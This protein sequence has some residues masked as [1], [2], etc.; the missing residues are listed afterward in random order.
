MLFLAGLKTT[1]EVMVS[2]CK[3]GVGM[4]LTQ[5]GSGGEGLQ[6]FERP[7]DGREGG[8]ECVL[9]QVSVLLVS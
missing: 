1:M 6:P 4:R 5:H 2:L 7:A 3:M 9:I 8:G